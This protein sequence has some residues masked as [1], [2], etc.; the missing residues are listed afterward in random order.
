[1]TGQKRTETIAGVLQ[2]LADPA[3]GEL[4]Q[5]ISSIK[6]LVLS[7]WTKWSQQLKSTSGELEI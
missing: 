2:Q 3:V 5:S 6:A 7:I 1:M 4:K